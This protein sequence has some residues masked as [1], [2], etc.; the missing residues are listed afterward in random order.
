M[1][2]QVRFCGSGRRRHDLLV[3]RLLIDDGECAGPGEQLREDR[4]QHDDVLDGVV[5]VGLA[6]AT[7][8]RCE[9]CVCSVGWLVELVC[10]IEA[11]WSKLTDSV[12]GGE[13]EVNG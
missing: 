3:R 1:L 12:V 7:S 10:R 6:D 8:L 9:R 11:R 5:R 2:V 13:T 4:R